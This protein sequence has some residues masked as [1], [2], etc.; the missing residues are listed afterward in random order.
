MSIQPIL[1][2]NDLTV[3]FPTGTGEIQ[4]VIS[5]LHAR[6][7]P[8]EIVA[9]IGSSGS[10]KSLL[11]EALLGVSSRAAYVAGHLEYRGKKLDGRKLT[12]LAGREIGLI[13]QSVNSLDPLMKIG[14]QILGDGRCTRSE[15]L[16]FFDRYQ[17]PTNTADKYPFEISGGMARRV[18]I[19]AALLTKPEMIIADE[20]TPGLQTELA[21]L[22]MDDLREFV[23]GNKAALVITHD[24]E[25]ALKYADRISVFYAGT[26]VEVGVVAH[27]QDDM[28]SDGGPFHPYT[29]ALLDSLPGREFAAYPGTQPLPGTY[30]GCPFAA[31]CPGR[32]S[33]CGGEIPSVRIGEAMVRCANPAVYGAS[34]LHRREDARR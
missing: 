30:S 10:G 26:T 27:W 13:P 2:I 11:A 15:M 20:P 5:S 14:K 34:K 33:E 32:I 4:P 19:A 16:D 28:R 12:A 17:L 3:G 25:L 6:V 21:E 22:V 24:A 18:L 1:A 7:R 9:I 29:R 31:R 23:K 8:G